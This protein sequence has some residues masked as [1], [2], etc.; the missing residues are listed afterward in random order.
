MTLF[1]PATPYED[2]AADIR[3]PVAKEEV[4]NVGKVK[5][6]SG[7]AGVDFLFN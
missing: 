7:Y 5:N 1:G 4:F 6:L 2:F 3:L